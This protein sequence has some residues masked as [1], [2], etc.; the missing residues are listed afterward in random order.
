MNAESAHSLDALLEFLRATAQ[1]LH[2]LLVNI[3]EFDRLKI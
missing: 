1:V 2:D 3:R